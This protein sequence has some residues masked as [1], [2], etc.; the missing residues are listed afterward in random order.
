MKAP[1]V[2]IISQSAWNDSTSFGNTFSNL[3]DD[4][5][6]SQIAHV[7]T[8]SDRPSTKSCSL[9]FN[10]SEKYVIKSIL[11]RNIKS[12]VKI[13]LN[14]R[15]PINF[16]EYNANEKKMILYLKSHLRFQLI[17]WFRELL[18]YLG[19]WK[20]Y[21]LNEFIDDF[22]PDIIFTTFSTTYYINNI[23]RYIINYCKKP[24]IMYTSD[25]GYT[26][27]QFSYS[28]LFWIDRVLKRPFLRKTVSLV[29]ILYVISKKQLDEYNKIFGQKCKTL[30]K[31][32]DFAMQDKYE[33]TP[34]KTIKFVYTGNIS[35]GRWQS[36]VEMGK[37]IDELNLKNYLAE[38]DV[39]SNT[40]YTSRIRKEISKVNSINYF[41]G[42]PHDQIYSIQRNA[43]IL[44]HCESFSLKNR[45]AVRL[46]FST[47]I[48][49]YLAI[50]RCIFAVGHKDCASIEY[51]IDNDIAV[52]ATTK[53]EIK[54]QLNWLLQN[55]NTL[56][57]YAD[58]SWDFGKNNHSK[59]I[60]RKDF[61]NDLIALSNK[62]NIA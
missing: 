32:A 60:R 49:D 55:K 2:L 23:E 15:Q 13:N 37:V 36:L 4:Y 57:E 1:K 3:F 33:L 38:I 53:K 51:L 39:Y 48:I 20:T 8:D 11:D 43:D 9:F 46:S 34:N 45:L 42:V 18:W 22:K 31:W 47:K 27:K 30:C 44:I 50:N 41:G 28:V 25:D 6:I 24:V 19:K 62:S 52:I 35:L 7:Y 16:K 29:D 58:K 26:L 40:P 56:K 10:I 21:E 61:Y 17:M 14:T 54:Q 59:E 5:D 12:G